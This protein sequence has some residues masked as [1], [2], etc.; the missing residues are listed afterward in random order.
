[1]TARGDIDFY[2]DFASPYGYFMSEK[3]DALARKYGRKVTWR[4]VMLFA[5]LR[6]LEKTDTLPRD[7]DGRIHSPLII[8]FRPRD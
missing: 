4:P 2:F 5:V 1:M 3:I 7:V 8:G 6:A